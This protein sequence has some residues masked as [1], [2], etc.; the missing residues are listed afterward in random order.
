M[1][2]GSSCLIV[3]S[4]GRKEQLLGCEHRACSPEPVSAP[5]ECPTTAGKL[6]ECSLQHF[7]LQGNRL[8][9]SAR[10]N[11]VSR[12]ISWEKAGWELDQGSSHGTAAS[13]SSSPMAA[14]G[15]AQPLMHPCS[16]FPPPQ[17][18]EGLY[19][20][21][22]T[23]QREKHKSD[24]WEF[25]LTLAPS[26]HGCGWV[27]PHASCSSCSLLLLHGNNLCQNVWLV[28][29]LPGVCLRLTPGSKDRW[30]FKGTKRAEWL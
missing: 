18:R 9:G 26:G 1:S 14:A 21:A 7:P 25:I 2:C 29:S 22:A 24:H 13:T 30:T 3:V 15:R 4:V 16:L 19:P 20:P 11:W 12:G 17:D 6:P 23:Q 28:S 8:G 10:G 5:P 27:H